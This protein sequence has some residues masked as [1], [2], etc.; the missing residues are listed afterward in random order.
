MA[1]CGCP[2]RCGLRRCGALL[3][4]RVEPGAASGVKGWGDAVVQLAADLP[5]RAEA[6]GHHV[7]LVDRL[8]VDLARFDEGSVVQLGER[9]YNAP[10]HLPDA[11]LDEARAAVG[12]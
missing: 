4:D 6:L 1:G 5:H 10:D 8:E 2:L 11:V 7:V 9:V 12:L 3:R